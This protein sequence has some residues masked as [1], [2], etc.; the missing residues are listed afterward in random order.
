MSWSCDNIV[1]NSLLKP[2]K[3]STSS[4]PFFTLEALLSSNLS[5]L[6]VSNALRASPSVIIFS[7]FIVS[8]DVH[9]FLLHVFDSVIFLYFGIPLASL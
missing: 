3:L 5:L 7:T 1:C 8:N 9:T 4:L 6:W 2:F